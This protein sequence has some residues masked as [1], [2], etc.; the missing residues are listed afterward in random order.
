VLVTL[1]EHGMQ[2]PIKIVPSTDAG[3]LDGCKGVQ[4][5]ARTDRDAGAAQRAGEV[6]DIVCELAALLSILL[7]RHYSAARSCART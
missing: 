6:N 2:H 4:H 1:H 7:L 5:C 3:S